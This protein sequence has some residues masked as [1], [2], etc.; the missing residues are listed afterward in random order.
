[1]R[2]RMR[3]TLVRLTCADFCF[4]LIILSAPAP[5][6]RLKPKLSKRI[7]IYWLL[8]LQLNRQINKSSDLITLLNILFPS[9]HNICLFRV[10]LPLPLA[11][12]AILPPNSNVYYTTLYSA[13]EHVCTSNLA[14]SFDQ[15]IPSHSLLLHSF[16]ICVH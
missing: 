11:A 16:D 5:T 2:S 15:H 10:F 13:L 3:N 4:R 6:R 7:L 12:T 9:H 8:Y 14:K 1:M